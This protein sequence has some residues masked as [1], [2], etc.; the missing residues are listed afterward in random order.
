MAIHNSP[1]IRVKCTEEQKAQLLLKFIQYVNNEKEPLIQEFCYMHDITRHNIYYWCEK[2]EREAGSK[3]LPAASWS[4]TLKKCT[5]KSEVYNLRQV[6][7]Q[8]VSP[9]GHIFKLKSMHGHRDNH[10]QEQQP[11]NVNISVPDVSKKSD[12]D[13]ENIQKQLLDD[14]TKAQKAGNKRKGN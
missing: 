5:A 1:N 8:G 3:E 9:G 2:E 12:S 6:N 4:S 13:L 10:G 7:K 14:I 11:V